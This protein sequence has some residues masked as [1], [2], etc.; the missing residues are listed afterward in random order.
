[1]A[2]A[3]SMYFYLVWAKLDG[4]VKNGNAKS[5]RQRFTIWLKNRKRQVLL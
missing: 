5:R 3:K 2:D 4:V 1:M